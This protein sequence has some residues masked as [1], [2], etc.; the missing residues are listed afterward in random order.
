VRLLLRIAVIRGVRPA[1]KPGDRL[2]DKVIVVFQS[3]EDKL[4]DV[5]DDAGVPQQRAE[6]GAAQQRQR[7]RE[8]DL[9]AEIGEKIA[10]EIRIRL[11]KMKCQKSGEC[12]GKHLKMNC[13]WA[14][15]SAAATG[16]ARP[17]KMGS[18]G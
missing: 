8:R 1:H 12:S 5:L 7:R 10:E 11:E 17:S 9:G 2:K 13:D 15:A 4:F 14:A 16:G 18:A 3:L 6:F